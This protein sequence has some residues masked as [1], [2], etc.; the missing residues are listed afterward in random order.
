MENN[1]QAEVFRN[2]EINPIDEEN[3][4]DHAEEGH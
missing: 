3:V 4:N 2:E 1:V